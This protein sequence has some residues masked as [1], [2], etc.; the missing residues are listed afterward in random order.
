[1]AQLYYFIDYKQS[2][3]WHNC[4]MLLLEKISYFSWEFVIK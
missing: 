2:E 1:M 4:A 3:Q